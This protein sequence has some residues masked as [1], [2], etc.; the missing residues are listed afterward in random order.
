MIYNKKQ[1]GPNSSHNAYINKI[2]EEGG[3]NNMHSNTASF[4]F[5]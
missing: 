1:R 4:N 3:G 5:S 2:S